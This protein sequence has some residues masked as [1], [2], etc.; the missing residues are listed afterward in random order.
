MIYFRKF[1]NLMQILNAY[2]EDAL[3]SIKS[4]VSEHATGSFALLI[5]LDVASGIS[6]QYFFFQEFRKINRKEIHIFF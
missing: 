3:N 6:A 2:I 1:L 4:N 5:L